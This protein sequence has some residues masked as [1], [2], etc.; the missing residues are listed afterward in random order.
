MLYFKDGQSLDAEIL[1]ANETHVKI[2]R[3]KDLQQFRFPINLLTIDTQKQI[4]LYFSKGRYSAI[5]TVETPINERTLNQYVSYI[6][7]LID[8][9]LRSKATK[10]S[11]LR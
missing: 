10:D 7:Q 2:A 3:S 5:P 8:T 11:S 1:D 4:E 9:N 6:D